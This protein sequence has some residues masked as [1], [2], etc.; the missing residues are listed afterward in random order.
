MVP[1]SQYGKPAAAPPAFTADPSVDMKT[2]PLNQ[3]N[4]MSGDKYF[5]RAAELMKLYPPHATDWGIVQRMK[6]IGLVP[7]Q[8]FDASKASPA[9]K[10]AIAE[11]PAA[12]SR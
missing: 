3:V 5:A 8:S 10:Q 9:V 11:A 4:G 12:G 6:Q 1:L 2:P 7:G